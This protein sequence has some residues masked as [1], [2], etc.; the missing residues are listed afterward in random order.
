MFSTV[1]LQTSILMCLNSTKVLQLS[2]LQGSH[3]FQKIIFHTFSLLNSNK[4][5]H[6]FYSF[7]EILNHQTQFYTLHNMA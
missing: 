4:Q 1:F 2:G 5:S 3:S 6:Y 7:F